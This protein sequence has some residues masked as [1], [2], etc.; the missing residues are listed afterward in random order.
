MKK[1]VIVYGLGED[2]K[3]TKLMIEN[4]FDVIGRCDNRGG[5]SAGRYTKP[6]I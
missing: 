3:R 5:N 4:R 2:Y 1:R 6:G